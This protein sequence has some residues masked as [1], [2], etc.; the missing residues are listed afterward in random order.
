MARVAEWLPACALALLSLTLA[1]CGGGGS[2][3]TPSPTPGP[4]APPTPAPTTTTTTLYKGFKCTS[5]VVISDINKIANKGFC[6]D[7]DTFRGC[8]DRMLGLWPHTEEKVKTIRLFKAWDPSWGNETVRDA[9]WEK[10]LTWVH[11]NDAKVFVGTGIGCDHAVDEEDWKTVKLLMTKLTPEHVMGLGVGNEMDIV[12]QWPG[13]TQGCLDEL[14]NGRFFNVISQRVADMDAM[15]F[16][17]TKI[18]TV[19]ATSALQNKPFREDNKAKV[20]TLLRKAYATWGSR[21]VWTFNI[22]AIWDR[23]AMHLDK[24]TSDQCTESIA[25]ASGDYMADLVGSIRERIKSVTNNNNDPFWIGETGWSS[26]PPDAFFLKQCKAMC[27][28]DTF[29]KVYAKFLSWDFTL[30]AKDA[31][32]GYQ[33]PDYAFYFANRDSN[34]MGMGEY[35]GL[36]HNCSET[37]CKL[38]SVKDTDNTLVV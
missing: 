3:P 26:P 38:Q 11:I 24:G 35:F 14:W 25:L 33:G 18:T 31:A 17:S 19:W 29:K 9:A 30:T 32:K 12:S 37:K 1:G 2:E 6:L 16:S 23:Q 13:V 5:D 7:D 21:W 20:T 22:Y 8:P 28:E 36:V 15:G 10:L 27:S 34:N 4:T